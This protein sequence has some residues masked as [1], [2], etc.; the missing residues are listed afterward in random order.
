MA[1]EKSKRSKDAKDML[2]GLG[3]DIMK[4]VEKKKN[5]KVEIPIRSMSNVIYDEKTKSLTLGGK[6]SKRY[7]FNVAHAKKFMQ[8]MMIASYCKQIL[9]EKMHTSMRDMYY[10]LKRTLPNSS[11]NT[12]EEQS[13]SDPII[14]DLEVALDVLR[15]QLHLTADVR[16]RIVG[17]ASIVDRGDTVDWSRL[18]SGGWA[19]PS[20]VEEIKF[21]KVDAKFI[22][23]IE[24]NAAFE[25]LHEDKF[26]DKHKC[27]LITTQGQPA[28]G[29]RRLIQRLSDEYKL[30]VY[31]FCD[32][33]PYGWYIYSVI[34][35]GSIS[36]AH[37]SDRLGTPKA[38]YIGLTMSDIERFGLEKY[39]IKAKDVDIKRAK[40]MMKYKWFQSKELQKELK[41]LI[42]KKYKAELE[43]LSGRGL[44]FMTEEYLP[45]KIKKK[46]FL[47]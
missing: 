47:P 5:P 29:C 25:R 24:K 7:M 32:S 9:D 20:N 18:G 41:T 16:G 45:D 15:E 33:D 4:D 38:K 10:N 27:V 19:I 43:A 26:W 39:T 37:V 46:D 11:E 2:V 23:V 28:R 31:V 40:D 35:F 42:N 17:K 21:R 1:A 44:R 36:L 22:L 8:T 6:T 14:V 12:F 13:E 30:P 3:R 34:K